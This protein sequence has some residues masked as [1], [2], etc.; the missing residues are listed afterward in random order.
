[1]VSTAMWTNVFA[2]KKQAERIS[3]DQMKSI[4]EQAE[5]EKLRLIFFCFPELN[6]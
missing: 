3:D 6:Y 1:M 4:K 2:P 5:G